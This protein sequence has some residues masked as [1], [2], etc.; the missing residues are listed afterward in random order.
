ML[1]YEVIISLSGRLIEKRGNKMEILLYILVLLIG[2]PFT[3]L[4]HETGHALALVCATREGVAKV[5]L[6]DLNGTNKENFRVGRIHYHI[7]WGMVGVCYIDSIKDMRGFQKIM[8]YIGGPLMTLIFTIILFLYFYDHP[9]NWYINYFITGMFW[10][11]II[12][13]ISTIIPMTYPKWIG[14]YGGDESDGYK[15]LKVLKR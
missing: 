9:F 8:V 1:K 7:V 11:N 3:I 15:I 6:D 5:Y 4:I 14:P 13:F 12:Q 10:M 2:L